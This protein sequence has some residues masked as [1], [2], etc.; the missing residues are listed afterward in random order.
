MGTMNIIYE[1]RFP[2]LSQADYTRIV[3]EIRKNDIYNQ[4]DSE[5]V[6]K[7]LLESLV[8]IVIP[9][10]IEKLGFFIAMAKEIAEQNEIDTVISECEDRYI[11]TFYLDC[12]STSFGL[13]ELIEYGDDI[14]IGCEG[15]N[16]VV[17]IIY[18]THR[19]YCSSKRS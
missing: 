1:K 6:V 11:A 5:A 12:S 4:R 18:F 3:K 15:E 9:E 2:K 19:T 8:R 14:S 7:N 16:A 13:K 17:S 10:R